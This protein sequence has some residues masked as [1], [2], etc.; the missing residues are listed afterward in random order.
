MVGVAGTTRTVGAAGTSPDTD[1]IPGLEFY[2]GIIVP[3]F[4][5]IIMPGGCGRPRG[6]RC[7][8]ATLFRGASP[9]TTL[10]EDPAYDSIIAKKYSLG[11]GFI[12]VP[13]PDGITE[14]WRFEVIRTGKNAAQT[15]MIDMRE[16]VR[17]ESC[18]GALEVKRVLSDGECPDNESG[19]CMT[20]RTAGSYMVFRCRSLE[21]SA[22]REQ[23]T[24]LT[25]DRTTDILTS[26]SA[27]G[28]IQDSMRYA[29][30]IPIETLLRW[31]TIN[32]ARAMGIDHIAGSFEAGKRPGAVL[33]E[34]V[35]WESGSFTERTSFRRIL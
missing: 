11:T 27:Y 15:T 9:A 28:Y 33:I 17:K 4:T 6:E 21:P 20:D 7:D 12:G 2:S 3:A 32:N 34:G 31:A 26:P 13:L 1:S 10:I 25:D 24:H 8:A 19:S 29:R 14:L 23:G 30:H 16:R 35:D 18:P 22:D 5:E